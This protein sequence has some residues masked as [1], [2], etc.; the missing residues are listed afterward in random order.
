MSLDEK[1]AAMDSFRDGE[2]QALVATPVIEVGSMY[3]TPR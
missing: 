3:R 1:Q 2:T